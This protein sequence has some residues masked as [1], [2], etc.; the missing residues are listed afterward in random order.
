MHVLMCAYVSACKHAD[1]SICACEHVCVRVCVSMRVNE[2]IYVSVVEFL[3]MY[4]LGCCAR[5]PIM[6][7]LK[8]TYKSQKV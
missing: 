2:F 3:C 8:I 1:V 5:T 4:R 6:Y 7:S